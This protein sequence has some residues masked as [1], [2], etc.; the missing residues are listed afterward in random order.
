[1]DIVLDTNVLAYALLGVPRHGAT[2]TR[3]L[4]AAQAIVVPDV[5]RAELANVLWQ[6]ARSSHVAPST[7]LALLDDAEALLSEVVPSDHLWTEALLL[8][9]DADHPVYDTLFV[10]LARQRGIPVVTHDRALLRRFPD[11]TVSPTRFLATV[12]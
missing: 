11:H 5:L 3:L 10:A 2:A 4:S 12:S 8:A 7:A 6:W 1:M 9:M